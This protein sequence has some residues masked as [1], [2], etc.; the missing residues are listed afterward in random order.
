MTI[1]RNIVTDINGKETITSYRPNKFEDFLIDFLYKRVG[2]KAGW[3]L[4]NFLRRRKGVPE[5]G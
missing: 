3:W 1:I 2:R 4:V 5:R